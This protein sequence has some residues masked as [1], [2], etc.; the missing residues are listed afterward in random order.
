MKPKRK[1]LVP[2]L[3][4]L[5]AGAF[6]WTIN[7]AEAIPLQWFAQTPIVYLPA[8]YHPSPTFT[9][10]PTVTRTPGTQV[11]PSPTPTRRVTLPSGMILVDHSD[12]A[13]FEQI[14]DQYLTA[15][16]ELRMIFLDRSVGD[17]ISSGLNC[18]DSANN[19]VDSPII[20]RRDYYQ[21]TGS[22]WLSRPFDATDFNNGT[23]PPSIRFDPDTV[24]YNRSNWTYV[25]YQEANWEDLVAH[26]LTDIVPGNLATNDVL[27]FEFSYLSISGQTDIASPT[28]GFFVDQPHNGYYPNRERWDISDIEAFRAQNPNK[29]FFLWTTSLARSVGTQTGTDFNNQIRQ[30]AIQNNIPL[31]DIADILSHDPNGNPCYDNRDG[32]EYC[33]ATGNCENHADDGQNY[34]AICQHYTTETDGGHLGSVSGGQ[35]RTAKALWVLMAQLAGWRP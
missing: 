32:V 9:P 17:N 27:T 5:L 18:L 10:S 34:P 29:I 28:S 2:V 35:I 25:Y 4:F 11:T 24:K 15:A 6:F 33:S 22:T 1:L 31:L 16:R 7:R 26:F 14:P 30:Y 3:F 19:W 8:V 23:V 21:I 12:L 13:L 20:C